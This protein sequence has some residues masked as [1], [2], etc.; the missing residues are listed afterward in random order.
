MAT[1]RSALQTMLEPS[2]QALG[3]ELWGV[4]YLAQGRHSILRIFIEHENGIGVE[5]CAA[6]SHHISGILDVEDPISGEYELEVSSPG[7]DRPL[8]ELAQYAQYAGEIVEVKLR[9]L[10]NMRRKWSGQMISAVD[11]MVCLQCEGE[12]EV[13]KIPFAAIEKG[14]ILPRFD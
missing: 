9:T 11:D 3:F 13:V 4:E 2:V 8:F 7:M 10:I 6:V 5:D 14:R 1:N 12:S